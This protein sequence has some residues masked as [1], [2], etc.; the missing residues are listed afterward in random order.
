MSNLLRPRP[1]PTKGVLVQLR[2]GINPQHRS[3]H[4]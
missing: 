1:S 2:Y 4:A 3:A